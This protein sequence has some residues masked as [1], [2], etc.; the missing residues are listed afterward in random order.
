MEDEEKVEPDYLKGFNEGYTIAQHLPQLAE[1]LANVQGESNRIAGFK[2]GRDQYTTERMKDRLPSWL[3]GERPSKEQG[4]PTKSRGRDI[5]L[6]K[7]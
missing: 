1:Q 4:T 2:A 3:K 5:E 6:D 7:D